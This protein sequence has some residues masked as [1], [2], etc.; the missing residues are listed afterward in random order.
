LCMF[1]LLPP[2][3]RYV[4]LMVQHNFQ[5]EHNLFPYGNKLRT[6][7]NTTEKFYSPN[8]T[9]YQTSHL[10]LESTNCNCYIKVRKNRPVFSLQKQ[11]L[12]RHVQLSEETDQSWSCLQYS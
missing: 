6:S 4:L 8:L 11:L 1:R 9:S 10:L 7:G 5:N 12:L 3:H 2:F